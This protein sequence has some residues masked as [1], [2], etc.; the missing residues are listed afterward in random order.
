MATR[1]RVRAFGPL[2]ELLF[3]MQSKSRLRAW[4]AR[5]MYDFAERH[6]YKGRLTAAMKAAGFKDKARSLGLAM[7]HIGSAGLPEGW[8]VTLVDPFTPEGKRRWP[9][10]Y[11][12]SRAGNGQPTGV[13]LEAGMTFADITPGAVSGPPAEPEEVEVPE[14][15][16]EANVSN[17]SS[18]STMPRLAAE[19]HQRARG[20]R[21]VKE[22]TDAEVLRNV[23]TG[24]LAPLYRELGV[25]NGPSQETRD[26]LGQALAGIQKA[27][28][29][30]SRVKQL[31]LEILERGQ[32]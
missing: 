1:A 30:L 29:E 17:G 26:A 11:A 16:A 6:R 3:E 24:A 5:E 13:T 7:H 27:S 4:K 8:K 19:A 21:G 12:I 2:F 10:N 31:V 14:E 23:I 22:P 18:L 25:Q 28:E 15:E 32:A 9:R 20:G